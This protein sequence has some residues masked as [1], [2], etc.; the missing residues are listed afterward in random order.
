MKRIQLGC[1]YNSL[2]F[3]YS[4]MIITVDFPMIS[5]VGIDKGR[6]FEGF[7][8]NIYEIIIKIYGITNSLNTFS[9]CL[10]VIITYGPS[11]NCIN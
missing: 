7:F 5:T 1:P 9:V 3:A 6:D 2:D 8:V 10:L 4:T 11:R